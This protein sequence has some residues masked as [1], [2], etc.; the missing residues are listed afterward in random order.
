MPPKPPKGA[1]II[2]KEGKDEAKEK[3]LASADK[4]TTIEDF[5]A[6]KKKA[7]EEQRQ[8]LSSDLEIIKDVTDK[9]LWKLQGMTPQGKPS[10]D[11]PR[12]YYWDPQTRT[13]LVLKMAFVESQKKKK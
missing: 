8:V 1:K 5:L 3:M 6:A 10:G 13:A 12:L 7:E 4:T 11:P 2:K 9:E